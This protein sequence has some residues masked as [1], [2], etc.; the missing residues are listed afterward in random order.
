MKNCIKI[1]TTI[2]VLFALAA[3]SDDDKQP[4]IVVVP[5]DTVAPQISLS[6]QQV[7]ANSLATAILLSITDDTTFPG[8][9]RVSAV[10]SDQT[11]VRDD[12]LS[13]ENDGDITLTVLPQQDKSG[14]TMINVT[15]ID[16]ANNTATASFLL[17]VQANQIVAEQLINELSM[18]GEDQE[19]SF[20]NAIEVVEDNEAEDLFDS[21]FTK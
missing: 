20:I 1:S 5:P 9:I 15:A 18:V 6:D 21:L 13:V 2:A 11:I 10:S 14:N 4:D 19:P 17:E 3:C 12:D 16:Q 7:M 8:A